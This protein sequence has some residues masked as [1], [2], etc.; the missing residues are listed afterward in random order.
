MRTSDLDLEVDLD[1]DR[2]R[3]RQVD[4]EAEEAGQDQ[5][6]QE[7][8]DQEQQQ[9]EEQEQGSIIE[10]DDSLPLVEPHQSLDSFLESFWTRQMGVVERDNPDF[11]TYPL[12]LARIK[13]V[14]KSDEEVKVSLVVFIK[15]RVPSSGLVSSCAGSGDTVG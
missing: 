12:P 6:Q 9:Q 13:K 3:Q 15:S 5:D 4:L 14:M 2:E 10:Y 8:E 11:R 1:L 7:E